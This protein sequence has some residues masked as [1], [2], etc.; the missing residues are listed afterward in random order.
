MSTSA[1]RVTTEY[2]L[3]TKACLQDLNERA[4]FD[5][6]VA[7]QHSVCSW[8]L[9][10][11]F[12]WIITIG[13]SLS[14]S[15][16]ICPK[17]R[18]FP[19]LSVCQCCKV[20]C[21]KT[22][23]KGCP[24]FFQNLLE[25]VHFWTHAFT[26]TLARWG[27]MF[28]GNQGIT[29]SYNR[30]KGSEKLVWY[31]S[32]KDRHFC[33]KTFQLCF[34]SS[35]SLRIFPTKTQIECTRKENLQEPHKKIGRDNEPAGGP[36]CPSADRRQASSLLRLVPLFFLWACSQASKSHV[37]GALRKHSYSYY[38][39]SFLLMTT[40]LKPLH[41]VLLPSHLIWLISSCVFS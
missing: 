23:L 2:Q 32:Y 38:S 9:V 11:F 39:V 21:R 22:L 20:Q 40:V 33:K 10:L 24:F 4:V 36:L 12:D 13:N 1:V 15:M 37:L 29:K 5:L 14:A 17:Q 28:Q 3:M 6:E 7:K 26:W 41:S 19:Q 18:L 8:V 34:L 27:K 16:K 30:K 31:L 35:K 25:T